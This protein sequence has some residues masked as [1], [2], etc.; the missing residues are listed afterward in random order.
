MTCLGTGQ[1][2]R[3]GTP[4]DD[5]TLMLCQLRSGKLIKIRLDMLSNRP[6][7]PN[8]YA[9]QGT[10]ACTK[11]PAIEGEPGRVWIG[12]NRPDEHRQ[13]RP[14]ATSTSTSPAVART[15]RGGARR[16]GHGGGDYH[17]GRAFAPAIFD[18]HPVPHRYSTWRWNGRP[19]DYVRKFRLPA[20]ASPSGSPTFAIRNSDRSVWTAALK[21]NTF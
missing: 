6:H 3:P 17:V 21:P 20:A 14:C 10:W 7:L 16:A 15:F 11:P 18:R 8:Y 12:D 2:Y 19:P 5:T 13:W 9:L 4:N 1:P